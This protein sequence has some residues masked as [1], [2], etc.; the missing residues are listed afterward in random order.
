MPSPDPPKQ[1]LEAGGKLGWTL[2]L[3]PEVGISQGGA[4]QG[5]STAVSAELTRVGECMHVCAHVCGTP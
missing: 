4:G 3:L 2:L 1:Q 5:K